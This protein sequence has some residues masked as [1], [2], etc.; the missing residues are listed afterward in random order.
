M[1]ILNRKE[2]LACPPNTLYSRYQPCIFGA[3]EIKGDTWTN[4]WL[5]QPIAD[6]IACH[7]SIEHT[8][9]LEQSRETGRVL[10]MDM[11]CQ[12]RDGCFNE[13]E[14]FAVWETKDVKALIYRLLDC[15]TA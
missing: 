13:D 6:S 14:L 10:T 15:V 9:L 11:D 3:L 7:D 12:S 2:F 1:R 5:Y 8:E 4:D